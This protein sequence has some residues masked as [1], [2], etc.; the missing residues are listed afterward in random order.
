MAGKMWGL[1]IS[2]LSVWGWA[3]EDFILSMVLVN[4]HSV[5]KS[6]VRANVCVFF[7]SSRF[8]NHWLFEFTHVY[9]GTSF[10]SLLEKIIFSF[11]NGSFWVH[12]SW[13]CFYVTIFCTYLYSKL[14]VRT[15]NKNCYDLH[16]CS[17]WLGMIDLTLWSKEIVE[18]DSISYLTGYSEV[19]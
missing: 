12:C 13:H 19:F 4:V 15:E 5:L 8:P 18:F 1:M 2:K 10:S 7:S 14:L 16:A 3:R 17:I 6:L 11:L 9:F